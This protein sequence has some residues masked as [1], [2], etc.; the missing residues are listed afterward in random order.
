MSDRGD[1]N[2]DDDC[3]DEAWIVADK[4]WIIGKVKSQTPKVR[5]PAFI[6][7]RFLHDAPPLV[8]L[9]T[10]T[11]DARYSKETWWSMVV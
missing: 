2:Y 9:D 7:L 1:D 6:P 4:F 3:D 5:E 11:P 10:M 8:Y